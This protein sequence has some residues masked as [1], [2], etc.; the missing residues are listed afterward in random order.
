MQVVPLR[1]IHHDRTSGQWQPLALLVGAQL[2]FDL[3]HVGRGGY[4]TL[5]REQAHQLQDVL[6]MDGHLLLAVLDS[7]RATLAEL[8]ELL[9]SVPR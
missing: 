8:R 3:P 1:T 5:T 4:I 2:P 6:E 9:A 7:D